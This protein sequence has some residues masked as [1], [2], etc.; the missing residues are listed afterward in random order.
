MSDSY[1]DPYL[2]EIRIFAGSF[3]P[4][5]WADCNGQ[6]LSIGQNNAL[7]SLIGTTYGGDG[8]DTFGL[9]DLQGRIPLNA[10]QGRGL[11][12]YAVGDQGGVE[13]VTLSEAQ[14]PVH[15]HALN[16]SKGAGNNANAQGNVVAANPTTQLY[17]QEGAS[18]PLAGNAVASSGQGPS[19]PHENRMPYIAIRYIL[20]LEGTFPQKAKP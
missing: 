3:A 10:G 15:T 11:A 17:A 12:P 1:P 9:P 18:Q 2:G 16:A 6:L 19:Q 7:Y 14:L 8:K 13:D 4:E 5:G 20:A